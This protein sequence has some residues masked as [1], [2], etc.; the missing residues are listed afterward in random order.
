LIRKL[1]STQEVDPKLG[2]LTIELAELDSAIFNFTKTRDLR[3]SASET[4]ALMRKRR[5]A[6]EDKIATYKV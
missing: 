4:L 5:A 1:F 2:E 6:L 3:G